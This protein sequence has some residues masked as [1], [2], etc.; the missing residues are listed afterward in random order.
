MQS[1]DESRSDARAE[2]KLHL[3]S[4]LAMIED[5]RTTDHV[6]RVASAANRYVAAIP[7]SDERLVIAMEVQRLYELQDDV[8]RVLGR[9]NRTRLSMWMAMHPDEDEADGA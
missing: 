3:V 6:L 9:L 5:E 4:L 8:K 7:D 2:L 1:S